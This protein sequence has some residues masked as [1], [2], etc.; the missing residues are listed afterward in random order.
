MSL[1]ERAESVQLFPAERRI[2][3]QLLEIDL[4]TLGSMTSSDLSERSGASRSSIDRLSR[5]LGYGGLKGMRRSLLE[6]AKRSGGGLRPADVDTSSLTGIAQRVLH[7]LGDRIEP[8][9]RSLSQPH[10]LDQLV[11][12]ILSA[13]CIGFF[14]A[15]ESAAVCSAIYLRLMRLGLPVQ[16]SQEHHTQVSVAGMMRTGDLA[17]VVSYSGRSKSVVW[18]ART[19]K[20]AGAHVVAVSTAT[21]SPLSKISDLHV[22]LPRADGLRGSPEIYDRIL[23][24]ALGQI[25][26]DCIA[27]RRPDLLETAMQVDDLF[28]EDRL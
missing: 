11:S 1:A 19:A 25:L 2:L 20:E 4:F 7:D 14:G 24:V 6:E 12:W 3:T 17:I 21:A 22:A 5:K 18:A 15:G 23:S 16:F 10:L 13:R 28:G 26:F 8:F 9:M 27:T